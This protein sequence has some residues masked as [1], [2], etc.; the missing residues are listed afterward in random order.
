MKK[1]IS[2]YI[3][4]FQLSFT[5]GQ[6]SQP[7]E[8]QN[9]A[10]KSPEAAAF[11]KYGEYPVDLSTGVPN[12]SI[13]I[14]TI[15]DGNFKL[16]ISLNYHASGIKVNQEATWVG[17]GW[18]LNYGAQVILSARDDIDENNPYID[19]IPDENEIMAYWNLHPFSFNSGIMTEQ[20]LDKSRVKDVYS[21]SSPTANGSFYINNFATNDVVV[22]P[23]DA[24]FKVK[25]LGVSRS[26]MGFE[27]TDSLGNNY[28]FN[29]T[30][31]L[32]VRTTTHNDTYISAWYVDKIQTYENKEIDFVYQ[33]D[34]SLND[35]SFSQKVDVKEI[36]IN[37]CTITVDQE[38]GENPPPP[39]LN[40]TLTPVKDESSTTITLAKKIKEIIFNSG[41][42]KVIFEKLN[43]REDL[44]DQNGYLNKIEIKNF[45]NNQFTLK[46]GYRLLYS[47]FNS[48][49][50][51]NVAEYYKKRLK[52]EKVST[53]SSVDEEDYNFVYNIINLPSKKSKAQDYFGY[54]NSS[55]NI[56]L[57]PTHLLMNPYVV[58][59]GNAN[60][61]VNTDVNQAG[62]LTEIH[63]P[64]KGWTKF[65]YESNQY[66][67]K[68]DFD[69]YDVKIASSNLLQGT[70]LGNETPNEGPGIDL[71][72][73][74]YSTNEVDC[75]KYRLIPFTAINANAQLRFQISNDGSIPESEIRHCYARIRIFN[76]VE[77]VIY[78]SGKIKSNQSIVFP[79]EN[80]NSGNILMEAY[81]EIMSI[82]GLQMKYVNSNEILKNVYGAGLRVQSI[83]NYNFE[84]SLL[85]KKQYEYNDI[86]S[87]I[88]TSGKLINN[89][90]TTFISNVFDNVT[91]K[92]NPGYGVVCGGSIDY[93]STYSISSNSKYGIEGNSVIYKYVKEEKIDVANNKENGY[94]LYNF[95]TDGDDIP[96]GDPSIQFYR[97]WKRGKV[98]VKKDFKTIGNYSYLL[99]TETN[100]YIDDNSKIATINGFKLFR[101][102]TLNFTTLEDNPNLFCPFGPLRGS[103]YAPADVFQAYEIDTFNY[104]IPWFYQ[105]QSI[106]E[107]NFYNSSNT[108]IGTITTN[109]TFNY[110]NP[111]HLQLSSEV[112]NNSKGDQ[113]K[114]QYYYPEDVEMVNEPNI[115]K[116]ITQN[117]ISI[118]LKTEVIKNNSIKIS[119]KKTIYKDWGNNLLAPE[120][121][122]TAKGGLPLETRI[123][124]TVMDTT[125][126]LPLEMKME[127][128]TP[129][130][131]IWGY[132]KTQPIAKIENATYADVQSQ[133]T[134]LQTLSDTGTE[135]NLIT[136]LNTLRTNLPNAMVSTYTYKPLVGVSTITD[137][138]GNRTTYEYDSLNRLVRVKD[139][140]GNVI[141]EN[142]YHYKD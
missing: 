104:Q 73:E 44:I 87:T 15:T 92:L 76:T 109:K 3:L 97:P 53:I 139:H 80:L 102:S 116:L 134:N 70:G 115:S 101:H 113:I 138:K 93:T 133:I 122:Q 55:T 35:I 34:G 38:L 23:P 111:A 90:T 45:E 1:I 10:P 49:D 36:G 85:L 48:G 107:E 121:I 26:N 100:N 61:N 40:H 72:P 4:C 141:S 60:R 114:V 96:L 125:N 136:A 31:E 127:N 22:F 6:E 78:D 67:G 120:I 12:I 128:G 7:I 66:Y 94:I 11:L 43:G 95:S 75:V 142:E 46:K 16:P 62:M 130:T 18:N 28:V 131:Y 81:G 57:I 82:D 17:L 137:A 77:E 32:S 119:E 91:L 129:V 69:R 64:T 84:N 63:Y 108:L 20:H 9:F 25:L 140:Q 98:L 19:Q 79:I 123:R 13:P 71:I 30:K 65:N 99:R 41:Q 56:D 135:A 24:S 37:M 8:L 2:L 27:I 103:C 50:E 54:Y 5:Y 68:D 110:D 118:P 47:Y 51:S 83:E 106:I 88:K 105:K 39:S 52:L 59:V 126:G 89:L 132:S 112:T 58:Q 42:S 86:D 21:F 124:F 117:K 14:Y 29:T 74:C 33:D